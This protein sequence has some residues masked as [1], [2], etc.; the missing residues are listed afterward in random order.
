[1]N[2]LADHADPTRAFATPVAPIPT[3]TGNGLALNLLGIEVFSTRKFKHLSLKDI[4]KDLMYAL[5][6]STSSKAFL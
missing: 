4:R 1:M 3:G 6:R 5:Q 2:G